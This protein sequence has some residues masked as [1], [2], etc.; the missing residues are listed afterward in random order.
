MTHP[1][2]DDT[3]ILRAL[4][5]CDEADRDGMGGGWRPS[6]VAE[7]L[8]LAPSSV[9]TRLQ[10]LADEDRVAAVWGRGPVQPRVS[11][12]P[13][14]HDDVDRDEEDGPAR[15]IWIDDA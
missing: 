4:R 6:T 11:Y 8:P 5:D 10:R 9:D 14:T 12:L 7:H 13:L 15:R 1:D 2:V 3:Q